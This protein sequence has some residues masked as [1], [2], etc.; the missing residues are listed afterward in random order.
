METREVVML[1]ACGCL[2]VCYLFGRHRGRAE[3]TREGKLET[4]IEQR[5]EAYSSGMCPL[6]RNRVSFDCEDSGQVCG[7]NFVK[8]STES[9]DFVVAEPLRDGVVL[10]RDEWHTVATRL[11]DRR[12]GIGAS[13]AVFVLPSTVADYSVAVFAPDGRAVN[14]CAG[15]LQCSAMYVSGRDLPLHSCT[16]AAE[17][18]SGVSHVEVQPGTGCPEEVVVVFHG[19]FVLG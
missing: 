13:R 1:L 18:A 14:A 19:Y 8:M 12:L 7:L 15:A 11:C 6:C 10:S 17:C 5:S 2:I 4:L 9:L 16:L 3:G